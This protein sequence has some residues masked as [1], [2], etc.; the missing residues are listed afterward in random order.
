MVI[1]LIYNY[2]ILLD[3]R[4]M[5]QSVSYTSETQWAA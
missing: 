5:H 1:I 3:K 2:G 4:D